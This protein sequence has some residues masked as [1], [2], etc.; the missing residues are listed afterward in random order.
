M[1]GNESTHETSRRWKPAISVSAPDKS[2]AH[3]TVNRTVGGAATL[4]R[5]LIWQ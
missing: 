5:A 3:Q 2:A 1:S 4:G